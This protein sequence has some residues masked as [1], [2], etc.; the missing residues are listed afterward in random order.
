MVRNDAVRKEG[1]WRTVE[2]RVPAMFLTR[3]VPLKGSS[4]GGFYTISPDAS[5]ERRSIVTLHVG[6]R[7][8][9]SH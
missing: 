9:S 3:S 8:Q 5:G 6:R 4:L 2:G 7:L 1:D